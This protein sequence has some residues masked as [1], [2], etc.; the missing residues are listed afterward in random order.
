MGKLE[1]I[2]IA[3]LSKKAK[4]A[5]AE[6]KKFFSKPTN[7]IAIAIA[8]TTLLNELLKKLKKKSIT[9]TNLD[10][11]NQ[12]ELL[13]YLKN[14]QL[15]KNILNYAS[16]NLDEDYLSDILLACERGDTKEI[17]ITGDNF[18]NAI[19][20]INDID[21]KVSENRF[22]TLNNLALKGISI[23]ESLL[24][25]ALLIIYIIQLTKKLI[26][27]SE[28][29]SK[30]RLK[31]IQKLIRITIGLMKVQSEKKFT[32]QLDILKQIDSFLV[33]F[34]LATFLYIK[35]RQILQKRSRET[36]I[37]IASTQACNVDTNIEPIDVEI[38]PKTLSIPTNMSEFNCPVNLDNTIAPKEPFESKQENF[39]C[40]VFEG[41]QTYKD[42]SEKIDLTTKAIIQNFRKNE[43]LISTITVNSHVNVKTVVGALSGTLVFAPVEGYIDSIETN[44]IVI[45]DIEDTSEDYLNE[46]IN[47]LS[48]D[49]AR[50][51]D[52][53][54]FINDYFIP[55][56]Y[57]V[58][59]SISIVDDTSTKDVNKNVASVFQSVQ[60]SYNIL[61]KN[62]D[63]EIQDM[64]SEANVKKHVENETLNVIKKDI[65]DLQEAFYKNI[66][67]LKLSAD[68]ASKITKAKPEEYT[69][70][71]YYLYNLSE[72]LNAIENPNDIE[73]TYKDKINEIIIKRY[74]LDK[75]K[76]K[77]IENKLNNFIKDLEKGISLGNWFDKMFDQY[78]KAKSNKL[79]SVK[80]WLINIGN[81]NNKLEQ[82]EKDALIN[83][84]MYLFSF[85][86]QIKSLTKKYTLDKKFTS[87][88]ET[89]KE[90]IF[91]DKYFGDLWKELD[92]LL[93]DID[94]I[95]K[96][97]DGLSLFS[98]YSITEINNE[99]YRL[100]SIVDEPTCSLPDDI[101]FIPGTGYDSKRYWLK[102]CAFATLASVT[103][104]A[105]GW[106]TG[107]PPPIGP[108]PFPV[109]YIPIKP[110][111][112]KYGF[113][114]IGLSICGIYI[115]P[116][117]LFANLSSGYNTPLGD[118]TKA[119]RNE[120]KTLKKELTLQLS[121][122]KRNVLKNYLDKTK[123]EIDDKTAQ[124][125]TAKE[126][127]KLVKEQKP[128]KPSPATNKQKAEYL[129][130][131]EEWVQYNASLKEQLL[132]LKTKRWTLEKKYK[133]VFQAYTIGSSLKGSTEP[134]EK[135]EEVIAKQYDKLDILT[136]KIDN[137]LAPLPIAMKP[138][139][140]N[141]GMTLKNPK[142]I[143]N[144]AKDL[145]ENINA[146]VLN[147]L[148]KPFTLKNEDLMSADYS[149]KLSN[150]IINYKKYRTTLSAANMQIVVKDAFP[151]YQNL[152]LVNIPWVSFLYKD[153]VKI[154][155]KQYGFP[156]QNPL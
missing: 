147:N 103:N 154:G 46:Q 25:F 92:S 129:Q 50:L 135:N 6:N 142:P 153:F 72:S 84:I 144:I 42:A 20:D 86:L 102:Y 131:Y 29:P 28:H 106:S 39:T 90:G 9:N 62:Y 112:T 151:A 71:E 94:N 110:I 68:N 123:K 140:A 117:T 113:I 44:K 85:Y 38:I 101:T 78:N 149:A 51:N 69:L 8:G 130:T 104:P 143:T 105:T 21:L 19:S 37:E 43:T 41:E 24:P 109:I 98:I 95:T 45:R 152:K 57:P 97:I 35:N 120:V 66:K 70:L 79:K 5:F 31:Y 54:L 33:A 114:V 107:F 60:K 111:M 65:D 121:N 10:T 99:P 53:K 136:D 115:F 141:F 58:M 12:K 4:A 116:W 81:K 56:L 11:E 77:D 15:T 7:L 22:A 75:Y 118:P 49:Y 1:K 23:T 128:K 124:I 3:K 93:I 17:D 134:I 133:I 150:S 59:L 87:K 13:K 36:L 34:S 91:I 139:S 47:L 137:I 52:I 16:N 100:Y 32:E 88:D 76:L 63:K 89:I 132:T 27:R 146:E 48:K 67:T 64:T 73:K 155:A 30:Y 122:L 2:L 148:T 14:N 18:L 145:N 96:N 125:D 119:L 26:T 83:K 55:S 61:K 108:I 74:F 126:V 138:N 40:N 80:N 156:G 82:T 127:I